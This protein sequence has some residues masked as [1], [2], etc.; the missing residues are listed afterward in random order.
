M[1]LVD[2]NVKWAPP[3]VKGFRRDSQPNQQALARDGFLESVKWE[4]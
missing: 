1:R 2:W 3:R 4:T